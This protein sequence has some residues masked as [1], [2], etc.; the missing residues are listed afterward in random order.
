MS[1]KAPRSTPSSA[2]LVYVYSNF[3]LAGPAS[4]AAASWEGPI[5]LLLCSGWHHTGGSHSSTTLYLV[6]S[7]P[8]HSRSQH[9]LRPNVETR[10]LQGPDHQPLRS[11]S[12]RRVAL[13]GLTAAYSPPRPACNVCALQSPAR[14][15]RSH[16]EPLQRCQ[17]SA[18][19]VI[20]RII[21]GLRAECTIERPLRRIL[22]TPPVGHL[23][24]IEHST[25][26]KKYTI[27]NIPLF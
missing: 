2:H 20:T 21:E 1:V 16:P 25:P 19:D 17:E 23:T 27:I 13:L 3:G 7:Y 6:G 12:E 18:G 14:S 15:L 11:S 26:P 9:R 4:G 22:A 5:P 24:K 8:P 10:L